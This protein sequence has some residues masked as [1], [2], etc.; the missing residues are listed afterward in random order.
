[1]TLYPFFFVVLCF[2]HT[3]CTIYLQ[4]D[5][6]VDPNVFLLQGFQPDGT[7]ISQSVLSSTLLF[8]PSQNSTLGWDSIPQVLSGAYSDSLQ[9][10]NHSVPSTTH[11]AKY[12]LRLSATP[13]VLI[14]HYLFNSSSPFLSSPPSL[15]IQPYSLSLPVNCFPFQ[16]CSAFGSHYVVLH[17]LYTSPFTA[18]NV[19][20][21]VYFLSFSG[22]N[23]FRPDWTSPSPTPWLWNGNKGMAQSLSLLYSTWNTSIIQGGQVTF[24]NGWSAPLAAAGRNQDGSLNRTRVWVEWNSTIMSVPSAPLTTWS[25]SITE[26]VLPVLPSTLHFPFYQLTSNSMAAYALFQTI[27]NYVSSASYPTLW[28]NTDV[29]SWNQVAANFTEY[30]WTSK[31]YALVWS[32]ATLTSAP[33]SRGWSA[34]WGSCTSIDRWSWSEQLNPYLLQIHSCA[35]LLDQSGAFVR[36]EANDA[37]QSIRLQTRATFSAESYR[38]WTS[39]RITNNDWVN[40]PSSVFL[41]KVRPTTTLDETNGFPSQMETYPYGL[42]NLSD[43]SSTHFFAA[44]LPSQSYQSPS[45]KGCYVNISRLH[46]TEELLY[47]GAQGQHVSWDNGRQMIRTSVLSTRWVGSS[48]GQP[49]NGFPYWAVE[50]DCSASSTPSQW[51]LLLPSPQSSLC[52]MDVQSTPSSL[53]SLSTTRVD[54]YQCTWNGVTGKA[55]F[56]FASKSS[57]YTAGPS[58]S[59][60]LTS[61]LTGQTVPRPV[62]WNPATSSMQTLFAFSSPSDQTQPMELN[63]PAWYAQSAYSTQYPL[64]SFPLHPSTLCTSPVAGFFVLDDGYETTPSTNSVQLWQIPDALLSSPPVTALIAYCATLTGAGCVCSTFTSGG[65]SWIRVDSGWSSQW[66]TTRTVQCPQWTWKSSAWNS[67]WSWASAW[68]SLLEGLSGHVG[69]YSSRMQWMR[70]LH[71]SPLTLGF[72]SASTFSLKKGSF[73]STRMDSSLWT[74]TDWQEWTATSTSVDYSDAFTQIDMTSSQTNMTSTDESL[75]IASDYNPDVHTIFPWSWWSGLGKH[76]WLNVMPQSVATGVDSSLLSWV[77]DLQLGWD[78]SHQTLWTTNDLDTADWPTFQ[79]NTPFPTSLPSSSHSWLFSSG[80]SSPLLTSVSRP[81]WPY[82]TPTQSL[83]AYTRYPWIYHWM[84]CR[85][86][87]PALSCASDWTRVYQND[88]YRWSALRLSSSALAVAKSLEGVQPVYEMS[89]RHPSLS[90]YVTLQIE[91]N[92]SVSLSPDIVYAYNSSLSQWIVPSFPLS[93]P[94]SF[95]SCQSQP[96]SCVQ[97]WTQTITCILSPNVTLL[98][99][100]PFALDASS[101]EGLLQEYTQPFQNV[102]TPVIQSIHSCSDGYQLPSSSS[103][104]IS[105]SSSSSSSSPLSPSSSSTSV[106]H[107]SSSSPVSAVPSSHSISSSSSFLSSSSTSTSVTSSS[108]LLSSFSSSSSSSLPATNITQS[109]QSFVEWTYLPPT[110]ITSTSIW[111]QHAAPI[112]VGVLV[113]SSFSLTFIAAPPLLFYLL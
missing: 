68:G 67:V 38:W 1:M 20:D 84:L 36:A 27:K 88:G 5:V 109:S 10:L 77:V 91:Q 29:T 24:A 100:V 98:F 46:L 87:F 17:G 59:L 83:A 7:I 52:V 13:S 49:S 79:S 54:S 76:V 73:L 2:V 15:C 111:R 78:A 89:N 34:E 80:D 69:P 101:L 26:V 74:E 33:F 21:W 50:W 3:W 95:Y 51:S 11:N 57:T 82:S 63:P 56:H 18:H 94:N 8:H 110:F 97:G 44:S 66:T 62:F 25:S 12:G 6:T 60:S 75:F 104:S 93:S 37:V 22:E 53:C 96:Y 42:S 70:L 16:F 112:F 86:Q 32:L 92:F 55:I 106:A 61:L 58:P 113:I 103:S 4:A 28:L 31:E 9:W 19:S 39:Y 99:T 47:D 43:P 30:D 72:Y 64:C 105:P 41:W 107:S 23:F 48:W 85:S 45:W 35:S 102:P 108:F 90:L 65:H 71:F 14:A 40:I 81:V